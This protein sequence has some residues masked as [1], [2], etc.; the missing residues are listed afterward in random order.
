MQIPKS[1]RLKNV[2]MVALTTCCSNIMLLHDAVSRGRHLHAHPMAAIMLDRSQW[3]LMQ[4]CCCCGTAFLEPQAGALEEEEV[5]QGK[6]PRQETM[7]SLMV[8][9]SS[10]TQPCCCLKMKNVVSDN[11]RRHSTVEVSLIVTIGI[12]TSVLMNE[13]AL[14]TQWLLGW[15][16]KEKYCE[17]FKT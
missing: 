2:R 14:A 16:R 11:P 13:S 6:R 15:R 17:N 1:R 4:S 7:L 3:S 10:C 8:S 12:I 9:V 5:V